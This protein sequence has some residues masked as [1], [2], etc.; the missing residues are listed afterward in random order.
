MKTTRRN[1]LALGGGAMAGLAFTPVPWKLLDDVSIWTQNWPWIP[2]PR[3]GPVDV[4]HTSCALC[5]GGCGL[6]VRLAGGWPVGVAGLPVI[7]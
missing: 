1:L 6:R 3:R 2:Q 7:R 4:K 5:P